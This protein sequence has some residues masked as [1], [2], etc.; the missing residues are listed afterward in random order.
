MDF[1]RSSLRRMNNISSATQAE[2]ERERACVFACFA[3]LVRTCPNNARKVNATLTL[4]A[5]FGATFGPIFICTVKH[6]LDFSHGVELFSLQDPWWQV[7]HTLS[8]TARTADPVPKEVWEVQRVPL[9]YAL[10]LWQK[11]LC[12]WSLCAATTP[13]ICVSVTTYRFPR[14]WLST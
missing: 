7:L 9:S 4:C 11:Q 8:Q 3:L 6:F 10:F 1:L 12:L 14:A 2:R 5:L 13:S